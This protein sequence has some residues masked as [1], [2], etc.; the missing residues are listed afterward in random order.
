MFNPLDLILLH[1]AKKGGGGSKPTGTISITQN[2]EYDVSNYA[3][4]DVDV[5]AGIVPTGTLQITQNG[6]ANVYEY[7]YANVNVN[8][9]LVDLEITLTRDAS[10]STQGMKVTYITGISSSGSLITQSTNYRQDGTYTVKG[11]PNIPSVQ[12]THTSSYQNDYVVQVG[13]YTATP[14][15]IYSANPSTPHAIYVAPNASGGTISITIAHS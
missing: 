12:I 15:D 11:I 5:P 7:E 10:A 2:G 4:A 1:K 13:G 6:M 3:S 14:Y 9:N 8:L